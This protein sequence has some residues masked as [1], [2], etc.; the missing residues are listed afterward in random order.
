MLVVGLATVYT[1]C[2]PCGFL[3]RLIYL[4]TLI[5]KNIKHEE[6]LSDLDVPIAF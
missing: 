2:M 1:S 6:S 4:R 3:L 5:K